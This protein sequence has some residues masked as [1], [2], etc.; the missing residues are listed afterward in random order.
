MSEREPYQFHPTSPEIGEIAAAFAK[1][2]GAYTTIEKTKTVTVGNSYTFTFAPLSAIMAMV[3]EPHAANGLALI[4]PIRVTPDGIA[5]LETRLIHESGQWFAAELALA[6]LSQKELG[7]DITYMARYGCVLLGICSEEDIDGNGGESPKRTQPR[8]PP[9]APPQGDPSV[10]FNAPPPGAGS[11]F[12]KRVY[13]TAEIGTRAEIQATVRASLKA[14]GL[15][16]TNELS[17]EQRNTILRTVS[18][19]YCPPPPGEEASDE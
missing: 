3:R 6:N 4:H 19:Q 17:D 9:P 15:E 14:F 1:A 7:G 18:E 12:W 11:V 16:S 13:A 10:D 2:Q 8:T 5:M